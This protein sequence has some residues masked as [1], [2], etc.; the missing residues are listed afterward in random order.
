MWIANLTKTT[1]LPAITYIPIKKCKRLNG[2]ENSITFLGKPHVSDPFLRLTVLLQRTKNIWSLW[3][4]GEI[5]NKNKCFRLQSHVLLCF[6]SYCS[7]NNKQ[8][9]SFGQ[10][11][12]SYPDNLLWAVNLIVVPNIFYSRTSKYRAV[13]HS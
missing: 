10:D 3:I 1:V 7:F 4:I 13:L 9:F 11:W 8:N 12:K 6:A 2:Q 5:L